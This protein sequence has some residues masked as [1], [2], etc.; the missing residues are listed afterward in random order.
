MRAYLAIVATLSLLVAGGHSGAA[1]T[2][3]TTAI[4]PDAG[5]SQAL[6]RHRAARVSDL[7]YNLSFVVPAERRGV[8]VGRETITF[9]LADASAPLP[10]DFDPNRAGALHGQANGAP[11]PN[12][13]TNGHI[14]VPEAALKAGA[15]ALTFEFDA[16][17]A[18]L[19]RND[20]FLY[21]IFVPARAHEA[22]PCFDQPDLKA[23]WTL[24]LDVPAGWE[25]L[26]NGAEASRDAAA[27]RTRVS[28][29]ET[30]PISTYLF[31]FAAGQ[32][33]IER[34]ERNG[35]TLRMFH[36]ETDAQKVARNRDAIFDLHASALAWLEDYTTIQYPFGKFDFLL[37][38]SFQF[39][40]MEHPGAIFYNAQSLLL[41]ESATDNQ[42]LERASAIAH[43]TAHLWFGDL[44]TMRWFDDVW[45]KE[46]F[47][48]LMAAKIVNPSFPR[49]NHELRFLLTYYPAAY[50]VDRTAGTNAIHQ[51]L[52]NLSDAGTLYG[53]IIYD[54]APIVMR[55]LETMLGADGFRNGLRD[56][57]HRYSYANAT[58]GDLIALLRE[59]TPEDL[60][61]WSRA[62]V[63]EPG[64]PI[65]RTTLQVDNGRITRL[66]LTESDPNPRR[67]LHWPQN[68]LVG[69][70]YTGHVDLVPTRMMT[71]RADVYGARGHIEPSFILPNGAGLGY[72]DF[73]LEGGSLEWLMAF[74]PTISDPL[75]RGAAWVTLWESMLDGDIGADAFIEAALKAHTIETDPLI[76]E[77]VLAYVAQ[78]YWQFLPDDR[79]QALAPRLEQEMIEGLQNASA[80]SVKSAYFSTLR[81]V[82]L[83]TP[84]L[85]WLTSVWR[86]EQKIDGLPLAETDFILL[87]EDLAVRGV[88]DGKSIVAQQIE[89]SQNPDRKARLAFV[90]PALSADPAERDRFFA[91]LKDVANRRHESWVLEAVRFL[92]HPLRDAQ[93]VRYV[94]PSLDL[95]QD[96]QRTGDIFF[97]KRWMDA[98][99][100]GHKSPAAAQGVRQFLDAMG[101]SYPDRLRRIVLSSADNLFRANRVHVTVAD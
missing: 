47:A 73:H 28:F 98:T 80:T 31:A 2:S 94:R 15:N 74:M 57:L 88:P 79:R 51:P 5:V 78:A 81:S 24:A 50:D 30:A 4:A 39:G 63:D 54:K 32:F 42:L 70:G 44:V 75:T 65:F 13:I 87:A 41:D 66:A 29:T 82:A 68:L 69:L 100:A 61:A 22:F 83:T 7:R 14:V 56:Y 89:R 19:N 16:G 52:A 43:E 93:A 35:R 8:I 11:L 96:I 17:D 71:G 38:P 85:E 34:A 12:R 59:R 67:R 91:S 55:Q 26:A 49:I 36:R 77:R 33:S 1:Q 3:N 90:A 86:G 46:V 95:L 60:A 53:N 25:T 23:R 45:T 92:N 18:P 72:G 21:T 64:R 40:G 99:L 58:W 101:T 6:A 20:D 97:P 37:V 10:V 9:T 62:W 48:N 84:T 27:G 76:K